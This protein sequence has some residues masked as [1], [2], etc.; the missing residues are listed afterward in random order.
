MA[1][2]AQIIMSDP[3]FCEQLYTFYNS[4][5][6][7]RITG[8]GCNLKNRILFY[9]HYDVLLMPYDLSDQIMPLLDNY[10]VTPIFHAIKRIVAEYDSISLIKGAD[11]S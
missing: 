8:P 9:N 7:F 11:S 3:A 10:N 4:S 6:Y 2:I 5:N 1:D